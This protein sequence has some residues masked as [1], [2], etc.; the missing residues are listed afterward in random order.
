MGLSYTSLNYLIFVAVCLA[1]YYMVPKR[2]RWVI[3]MMAGMGFYVIVCLKYLCFVLLTAISTYAGG[4]VLEKYTQKRAVYIKTQRDVW[5]KE[6][7]NCYK[8]NT[9]R[10]KKLILAG[11]LVLNFG[12]LAFL[13]YYNFF[14]RSVNEI[15]NHF[16]GGLPQLELFL[17]LGISFYTFQSMGYVIDIYRQRYAA[18]KNFAKILLFVSFFPQIVQGPISFYSDL[19]GQLYG[20][21]KF[22]FDNIKQGVLLITWGFFKKLVIA[23]RLANT[24]MMIPPAFSQYS[25][26][27]IVLTTLFYAVQLYTDF[28][29]GIDVSRGVAQLFGINLAENFKRPYFSRN[30]SEYWHR[31]HITLGA[32]LREYLFY[33]IAMS[34]LFQKFG[35]KLKQNFGI[36]LSKVL[37]TS[38]A[39]LI[40]FVVVGVWHGAYWKYVAF[41]VWNGMVI[42]VSTLMA[43]YFIRLKDALHIKDTNKLFIAFQMVRTFLIVL[44]GYYFD[45]ATDFHGAV[46]MM[47][48]SV[49]DFHIN[50][51]VSPKLYEVIAVSRAQLSVVGAASTLVLVVSILQ[52]HSNKSLRERICSR[53]FVIQSAVFIVL[54]WLTAIFGV[55]GPGTDTVEFVYMQF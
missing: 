16:G 38:I 40:T 8:A 12:I 1:L 33:P 17:P 49:T 42:M 48:R 18:E 4:I 37:P 13:K 23:D 31:W 52:E 51:L 3:L 44:I 14:A 26:T 39:S 25:G 41:G 20:G 35:K 47:Y 22:K 10:R 7:K 24:V 55:Y 21:S 32:W 19:A 50:E 54:F 34:R 6:E 27:V 53:N 2:C 30:L 46:K 43:D 11:I 28:S 15:L 36:K 5:T 45:I 9:E 29:G